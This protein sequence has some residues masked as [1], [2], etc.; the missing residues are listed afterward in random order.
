V[1]N[2]REVK[3]SKDCVI[4]FSAQGGMNVKPYGVSGDPALDGFHDAGRS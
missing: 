3:F 1:K 2:I 4:A